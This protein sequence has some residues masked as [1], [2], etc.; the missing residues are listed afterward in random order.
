MTSQWQLMRDAQVF[1]DASKIANDAF[2]GIHFVEIARQNGQPISEAH[3]AKIDRG[4]ELLDVMAQ[5]LEEREEQQI[6]STEALSVLY[7]LS[8]GRKVGSPVM[9]KKLLKDSIIELQDFKDGKIDKPN[10]AEEFLEIIAN[11]TSEKAS[12]AASKV[13]IFMVEAR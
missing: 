13:N 6:L 9:L 1:L 12:N 3:V 5:A 11:S 4:I 10:D 7:V 2:I 8:E